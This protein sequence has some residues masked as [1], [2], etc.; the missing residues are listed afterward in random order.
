MK[1]LYIEN[2]SHDDD[3]SDAAYGLIDKDDPPEG[4]EGQLLYSHVCS[5]HSFAIGD[6]ISRRL[7]RVEEL[8]NKYGEFEVIHGGKSWKSSEA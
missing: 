4:Y 8:T 2:M 1:K 7:D 5:N 3:W 6:L